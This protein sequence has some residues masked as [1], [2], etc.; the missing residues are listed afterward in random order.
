MPV[1][2]AQ[3]ACRPMGVFTSV[4]EVATLAVFHPR[5]DL[6]LGGTVA[7]QLSRDKHQRDVL[8]PLEEL[9]E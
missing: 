1:T 7:L 8:P 9:A 6:A 2:W 4:I 3:L 5:Q